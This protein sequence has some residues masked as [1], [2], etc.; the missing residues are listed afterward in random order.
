MEEIE[1]TYVHE[2]NG[3]RHIIVSIPSLEDE[4]VLAEKMKQFSDH[5]QSTGLMNSN[6]KIRYIFR[7]L[8]RD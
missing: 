4:N 3:I 5:A 7:P 2:I 6:T 8:R 1:V